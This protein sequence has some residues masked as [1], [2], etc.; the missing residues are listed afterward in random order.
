MMTLDKHEGQLESRQLHN[1]SP[2]FDPCKVQLKGLKPSISKEKVTAYIQSLTDNAI[3]KDVFVCNNN[4]NALV[5][6]TEQQDFETL[7]QTLINDKKG[8]EGCKLTLERVPYCTCVLVTGLST[9]TTADALKFYFENPRNGC[10]EEPS[11]IDLEK[12][13]GRAWIHFKNYSAL[14]KLANKV[15]ILD[16]EELKIEPYYA[17]LEQELCTKKIDVHPEIMTYIKAYHEKDLQTVLDENSLELQLLPNETSV[18]IAQ[19]KSAVSNEIATVEGNRVANVLNFLADFEHKTFTVESNSFEEVAEGLQKKIDKS[20][21]RKFDLSLDPPRLA[22]KIVGKKQFTLNVVKEIGMFIEE[23]TEERRLKDSVVTH[24]EPDLSSAQLAVIKISNLVDHLQES[25][26]YTCINIDDENGKVIIDCPQNKIQEVTAEVLRFLTKVDKEIVVLS[27]RVL[28]VFC[29][30][31]G[32]EYVRNALKEENLQAVLMV[33][34]KQKGEKVGTVYAVNSDHCRKAVK[35]IHSFSQEKPIRLKDESMQVVKKRNWKDLI[36]KQQDEFVVHILLDKTHATL[37]VSGVEQDV[38]K[39]SEIVKEHLDKYTIL[40]DSVD[41]SLGDLKFLFNVWKDKVKKVKEGLKESFVRIEPNYK[42]MKI[43]I[44]GNQY[45]IK[46]GK[47]KLLAYVKRICHQEVIV[48]KP[49]MAKFFKSNQ[50]SNQIKMV[51]KDHSCTIEVMEGQDELT[52]QGTSI[53]PEDLNVICSKTTPQGKTLSVC[54]DDLTKHPADVIVNA[55]NEQLQ[56]SGGLAGAIVRVGGRQIQQECDEYIKENGSLPTGEAIDTDSGKL[57]C[58]RI[59]H[60]VGP[61]WSRAA[62]Q[63]HA[64]GQTTNEEKLLYS[65]I[66]NSLLLAKDYQSIAIPAVS[67]GIY[68]V[69]VIVCAKKIIQ[70]VI[71]FFQR[72]PHCKLSDVRFTNNDDPTVNAFENEINRVFGDEDEN[73]EWSLTPK[74]NSEPEK[75]ENLTVPTPT[76]PV[77]NNSAFLTLQGISISVKVGDISQENSDVLVNTAGEQ[78]NLQNNNCAKAFSNAAGP[79][80]QRS[81]NAIAPVHVGDIGVT[82]PGNLNCKH[83]FHAVCGEWKNGSGQKVLCVLLE[84]CLKEAENRRASSISIPAIG[85]GVLGFPRD[86]VAKI[87]FDEV[88]KFSH[89]CQP[90]HVKEV[91]FVVYHGDPQTVNCFQDELAQRRPRPVRE[92]IAGDSARNRISKVDHPETKSVPSIP[93]PSA[94][95]NRKPKLFEMKMGKMTVQLEKGDITHEKTNAIGMFSNPLLDFENEGPTWA[96]IMNSDAQ[97]II[98][99]RLDMHHKLPIRHGQCVIFPTENLKVG[100]LVICSTDSKKPKRFS[101]HLV[102]CLKRAEK[103]ELNSIS[104]PALGTGSLGLSSK[105]CA[106]FMLSAAKTFSKTQPKSLQLIRIVVFQEV[107]IDD[108]VAALKK[109]RYSANSFW[110]MAKSGVT[111]LR[112]KLKKKKPKDVVGCSELFLKVYSGSHENLKDAVKAIN[113]IMGEKCILQKI[114]EKEAILDIDEVHMNEIGVL[115]RQLD[116]RINVEKENCII[117]IEGLSEDVLKASTAIHDMLHKIVVAKHERTKAENI[118]KDVQWEYETGDDFIPYSIEANAKIETAFVSK[119]Q[120]VTFEENGE[121]ITIDFAAMIEKL[122]AEGVESHTNIKRRDL[123]LGRISVPEHWD[124]QPK[125]K[126]GVENAVHLVDLDPSCP[127]Y[128]QVQSRFSQSCPN[129]II[130][131]SRVQNPEQYKIYSI[132]KQKMDEKTGSNKRQLFHGTAA[133]SCESINKN[134]FNR[135]YCGKNATFYGNGVYFAVNA[136]YSARPTYSPAD[137]KGSRYMYLARVLT[138]NYT[139]GD[140]SMKVPPPKNLV[141]PSDTYDTVVDSTS[142][143]SIFVV[144]YDGQA[145]PEYLIEFR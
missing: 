69:P 35:L 72:H 33:N 55:A 13:L 101:Q 30:D 42:E 19:R 61:R 36:A 145:Y 98:G 63:R 47:Q 96:A 58:K 86:V 4:G 27:E 124:K 94:E 100:N 15:H 16:G 74:S 134:G 1:K 24:I 95:K 83:V 18:L 141:S 128:L 49:G 90:S 75:T 110:Q 111:V 78:L 139:K 107:M 109:Y 118:A 53:P 2:S 106:D 137:A 142:N 138:G 93:A 99:T 48:E 108:F 54:K 20:D 132:R 136:E 66:Q 28:E 113:D 8:L 60:A 44:F 143:P 62:S 70:S 84:K 17:F 144:F 87:S 127:E 12:D 117:T 29:S 65:A 119:D 7:V 59:V 80:L 104:F 46:N 115:E 73:T 88:I 52:S 68:G 122:T 43:E 123:T 140:S 125:S 39:C 40:Y 25:Y 6:F 126:S 97:T 103:Q 102:T 45:G 3:V 57:P 133:D 120:Y 23:V 81:C 34:D 9:V 51:E 41:I 67:S 116:C 56:H 31:K 77:S 10:G 76:P 5:T 112:S 79:E 92:N 82:P 131:I 50:G 26:K 14:E 130:K 37:W 114:D 105:D 89:K 21:S 64:Q 129:S 121:E 71:D 135:S 38:M 91:R 22:V 32:K 85:T 11:K